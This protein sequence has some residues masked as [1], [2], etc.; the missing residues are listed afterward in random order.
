MVREMPVLA[1]A[2]IIGISDTRLWRVVHYYVAQALA[3]L[4]LRGVK[5]VAL[6][7]TASRRRHN[8]V[9][10]FIDLDRKQKPAIFVTLGKGKQRLVKFRRFLHGIGGDQRNIAEMVCDMS[11][12]F[13][14][15]IADSFPSAN[16]TVD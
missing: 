14:A 11:P 3:H 7:E 12:A 16:V 1:A 2:R 9:T 8:Y 5:A 15:A 4:D 13:L 6:G 10:V